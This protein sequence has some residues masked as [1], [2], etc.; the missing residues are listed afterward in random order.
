M[1]RVFVRLTNDHLS[2]IVDGQAAGRV[3]VDDVYL[4]ADHLPEPDGRVVMEAQVP[5]GEHG[6]ATR[7]TRN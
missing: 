7:R 4:A 5:S 3:I 2:V 6:H 1:R